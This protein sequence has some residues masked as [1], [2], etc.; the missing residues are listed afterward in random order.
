MSHGLNQKRAH[1]VSNKEALDNNKHGKHMMKAIENLPHDEKM[2]FIRKL[3]DEE[4]K[5]YDDKLL[6]KRK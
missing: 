1:I 5:S 3:R 2:D 6:A 4:Q